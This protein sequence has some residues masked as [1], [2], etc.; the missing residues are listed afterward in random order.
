MQRKIQLIIQVARDNSSCNSNYNGHCCTGLFFY[1][2]IIHDLHD[3][4]MVVEL[5]IGLHSGYFGSNHGNLGVV[6]LVME[7][8]QGSPKVVKL[9]MKL[10][11][12]CFIREQEVSQ[13]SEAS[14]GASPCK[15]QGRRVHD[16]LHHGSL[17]ESEAS[18]GTSLQRLRHPCELVSGQL[19]KWN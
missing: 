8:H 1:Q 10:H 4:M 19:H 7:H 9:V 5:K 17:K 11:Q 15:L 18:V 13:G 16:D 6:K 2:C 12:E 3:C 14:D